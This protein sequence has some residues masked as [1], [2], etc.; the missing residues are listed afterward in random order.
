M[1]KSILFFG[2]VIFLTACN[3]TDKKAAESTSAVTVDTSNHGSIL[4]N[5]NTNTSSASLADTS[6]FTTIEWIDK[7]NQTLPKIKEGQIQEVSYRFKNTGTKPLIIQDVTASCGCTVPEK[8]EK[9]VLPGEEGL[10]KA[11]FD[12]HGKVGPNSKTLTVLANTMSDKILTFSVEVEKE[13]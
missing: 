8:P 3:S 13:L 11:K 2:T 9:P 4:N 7:I 1:K 5:N 12:S 6:N 10:I